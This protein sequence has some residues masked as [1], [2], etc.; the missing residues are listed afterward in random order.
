MLWLDAMAQGSPALWL[1]LTS[2]ELWDGDLFRRTFD[3]LAQA[4][5]RRWPAFEYAC[6]TEF[7]TGYGVR[8]GGKRRPH[9][10][11]FVRGV[12][13]SAERELW[14]V[15]SDVWCRH[16]DALPRLQNVYRVDDDKGGMRGLTR[17]VGLHFQKESQAPP[18]GWRG[19]RF[20]ASRG[21]F[22]RSRLE[23]RAQARASLQV[24]RDAWKG[25]ET[26]AGPY[27]LVR[28]R[29]QRVAAS[30]RTPEVAGQVES[31]TEGVGLS[32]A[33]PLY[34]DPLQLLP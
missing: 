24:R 14:E 30:S 29:P 10:N 34:P 32:G 2:R 6:L 33:P 28:V 19:Q 5:R 13:V 16:L 22:T 15:V 25:R 7:T 27:V 17:Y 12:P 26:S 20:R 23:L 21:Y 8:S 31:G 18:Q 9:F 11:T 4:C 1:L 3:K